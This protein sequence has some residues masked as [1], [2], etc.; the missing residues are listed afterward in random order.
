[1]SNY[2][3]RVRFI[4]DIMG[5]EGVFPTQGHKTNLLVTPVLDVFDVFLSILFFFNIVHYALTRTKSKTI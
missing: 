5:N 4:I 1:M 2:S 3:N